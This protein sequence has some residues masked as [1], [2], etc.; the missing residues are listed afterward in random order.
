[1][2]K[3]ARKLM[4]LTPLHPHQMTLKRTKILE[5][6]EEFQKGSRDPDRG[7]A[8]PRAPGGPG[9]PRDK[10]IKR[11]RSVGSEYSKSFTYEF[12]LSLCV[13]FWTCS[14]LSVDINATATGS[15]GGKGNMSHVE[16]DM[17]RVPLKIMKAN[18]YHK[19]VHATYARA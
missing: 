5:Q 18:E 3:T 17:C 16:G 9:K 8:S 2:A 6:K 14:V 7:P 11:P 1:M 10:A 15:V 12:S 19:R 4:K 13:V